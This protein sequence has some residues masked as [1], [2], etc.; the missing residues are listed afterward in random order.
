MAAYDFSARRLFVD[1]AMHEGADLPLQSTQAHYLLTVLRMRQG[2]G[3]LVFNGRDG[4]W[5][6]TIAEATRKAC[7][8]RLGERIRAQ[9]QQSTLTYA[10]APLKSARLDYLVQKAVE[11]GAGRLVPVLTKRTQASK[12]NIDR[13]EA[14]IIEAAEQCGILDIATV[15]P[16]VRLDAFIAG[17]RDQPGL[18]VFCDEDQALADPVEGAARRP[19]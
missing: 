10:F 8:L 12:I 1:G 7:T 19:A 15:Q 2:D 6:A 5:R 3:L 11:M 4:E 13:M 17:R 14:N 16:A 9:P 18:L